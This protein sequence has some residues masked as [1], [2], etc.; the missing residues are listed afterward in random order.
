[1]SEARQAA[2][3]VVRRLR[4]EGHTAYFAGGCVRDR[5]LGRVPKD[6]DVATSARPEQVQGLFDRTV[7]VGAQFGVIVVVT[8]AG[9]IEVATFRSDGLYIDGRRPETIHYS[10]AL[11]DA[12]RRD[13][14]I[15]GLFEDPL[16]GEVIDYVGGRADLGVRMLRAIG[17]PRARFLEDHLRLLRAVR[18]SAEL[19]FS[20][21]T[22]TY[23]A[24]CDA[25]PLIAKV[26]QERVLHELTRTL[27]A[28][29]R[30]AGL[31]TLKETGL[32]AQVLPE[33]D[34][35]EG[36][37]QPPQFHPEGD[38]WA[39]QLLVMS[40]LPE[41][42]DPRLAWGA[43]L[44]DVGKPPTFVQAP[45]RIRFDGH[46]AVGA[47]MA[48]T[49]MRR[50]KSS[51]ELRE[52]TVALVRDHLK[53]INVPKM[54][55]STLKR[56]L[57]QDDVELH[58]A[59]HRAD[60]LG[61]HGMLD[62][63]EFCLEKLAQFRKEGEAEAL[64]PKPLLDGK[65]LI[66]LGFR[67]GPVFREILNAIETAQLD[68]E[69]ATRDEAFELIRARAAALNRDALPDDLPAAAVGDEQL[70]RDARSRA[71]LRR[72]RQRAAAVQRVGLRLA[73]P[74]TLRAAAQEVVR[75][76]AVAAQVPCQRLERRVD[77][78]GPAIG[79]LNLRHLNLDVA[80]MGRR[81]GSER[82]QQRGQE[83]ASQHAK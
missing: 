46:D 40:H 6:Y 49:I 51:R 79:R 76:V 18:F 56:F 32:L 61:C 37:E 63:Y 16:T 47:E 30:V 60:C 19:G 45:D 31:R 72:D 77:P 28:K 66:A 26:A 25:A 55:T 58:L 78:C 41:E 70:Q 29:H 27:T 20:I 82:D 48:D 53:F 33:I 65:D 13:F 54:K 71:F 11:G 9:P 39:H 67:P 81:R 2:T 24:I 68:E 36:V 23:A 38:C 44:H 43:L 15:N 73:G 69:V 10:D 75:L 62:I 4:S 1:M 5:L 59:L 74:A 64:R 8:E 22:I 14:T 50:L 52:T 80:G 57:R 35:L 7:A 34:A 42:L 83:G 21:E 3:E 12:E 17:N